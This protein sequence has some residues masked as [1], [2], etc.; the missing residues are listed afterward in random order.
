MDFISAREAGLDGVEDSELLERVALEGRVLVSHDRRTMLDHFRAR[1]ATG[2][3]S[4]GLLIVPQDASIGEVVEALVYIWA[5][6]DPR[7]L[8]DQAYYLPSVSRHVYIR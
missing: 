4:P 8:R 6:S 7:E 1:L 5:L 3:S 2:K